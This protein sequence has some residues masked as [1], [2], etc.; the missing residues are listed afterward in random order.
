MDGCAKFLF[1]RVGVANSI[2]F[3]EQLIMLD[4]FGKWGVD[5]LGNFLPPLTHLS[6]YS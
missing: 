1:N 4:M 5:F 2:V 6:L 3:F